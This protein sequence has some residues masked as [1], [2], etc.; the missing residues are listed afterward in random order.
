M[1][2]A[3]ACLLVGALVTLWC[4]PGVFAR[5]TTG[6]RTTADEPQYLMTAESLAA[7]RDLDVANQR[8]AGS[9]RAYHE[10]GLPLQEEI[11]SDAS[12]ISPH[13]PLLPVLLAVPIAL[14][15]WVGA[16]AFLALVAGLLAA[17]LLFVAE[18]RLGVRRTLAVPVVLA[19]SLAAPLAIYATQVYPEIVAALV[20]ALT[21]AVVTAPRPTAR[22]A[23]VFAALVSALP[24]LSVKYAPVALALVGVA[25]AR[26][27]AGSAARSRFVL[28][29]LLG[30]SAIAFA[31]L[32][33]R[34][35][36][37][38]TPYA[39]G[40]HFDAG[41]LDVMGN[42]D[43]VGRSVR[44]VGLFVDRDFGLLVWQPLY[45]VAVLGLVELVRRRSPAAAI[46]GLPVLAGWLNATFVALT[47]HGW[48]FP[49]RQVVVVLPCLVLA[50]AW[51]CEQHASARVHA[52]VRVCAVL[53]ASLAAWLLVQ[54][55]VTDTRLVTTFAELDHPW[56]RAARLAL[57]DLRADRPLD[58]LLLFA[59][60]AAALFVIARTSVSV[61]RLRRCALAPV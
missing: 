23:V 7:D 3:R 51:W 53:G 48:W 22:H 15:G 38:L 1:S 61:S 57:P 13:D 19:A 9:Y 18:A 59:W 17:A 54:V 49:G 2:R 40:S 42:P 21:I 33:L 8:A 36:G 47:M 45:A 55:A 32:H 5:A 16:K 20:V 41:Q 12:R 4:L 28:L 10:V 31:V 29:G 34:W 24:W 25:V 26:S 44:L 14:G 6:A 11:A 46:L 37:G 39:V 56:W 50:T 30:M 35:Y 52:A 58:T 43:L 60:S 27:T